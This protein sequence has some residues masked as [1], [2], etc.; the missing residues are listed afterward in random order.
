MENPPG[1][2]QT[3]EA[4][5]ALLLQLR[6]AG[7]RD[8]AVMRAFETVPREFFAPHRFQDLAARNIALPIG[9][10]QTMPAPAVL[11]RR[12]EALGVERRHRVLEIGTGSG[13]GAALLARLA[14]EVVSIE[15]FETLAIEARKRLASLS[16]ANATVLFADGLALPPS[17]GRF[18]RI[19]L[20]MSVEHAP[21]PIL[22]ALAPD[23]IAIFG[24][25]QPSEEGERPAERLC[26]LKR[27]ALGALSESDLGPC[28]QGAALEGAARAL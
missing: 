3:V 6:R 26:R 13:Y 16:I 21:P 10:G 27:D 14:H 22:E 12:F 17:L 24:R 19:V 4:R 20:H 9:C 25:L 1:Q 5:A 28:R 23:G 8:I 2:A 7:V 11:A 15:R 18:D